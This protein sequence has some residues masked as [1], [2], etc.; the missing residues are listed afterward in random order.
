M[1][2]REGHEGGATTHHEI[3][4]AQR[5]AKAYGDLFRG[6]SERHPDHSVHLLKGDA[7]AAHYPDGLVRAANDLDLTVTDEATFWQV[8]STVQQMLP[9]L[10]PVELTV[11]QTDCGTHY[12]MTLQWPSEDPLV[13][14]P[15]RVELSSFAFL[16]DQEG[17]PLRVAVPAAQGIAHV[18]ALAQE[19][20]ERPLGLK[21]LMDVLALAEAGAMPDAADLCA[22]ADAWRLAPEVRQLGAFVRTYAPSAPEAVVVLESAELAK[23][24]DEERARRDARGDAPHRAT[25]D[26]H[27]VMGETLGAV[28]LRRRPSRPMSET[29]FRDPGNQAI[30]RTPVGDY[31]LAAAGSRLASQTYRDAMSYVRALPL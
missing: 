16:G 10:R 21:D 7:I 19:A 3:R 23:A 14:A 28:E 13:D 30:L 27:A 29:A 24:A 20:R 22:A 9:S 4:R 1:A 17:V 12:A 26:F 15:L 11:F 2:V 8:A 31:L 6:I 25:E 18:L 5:R